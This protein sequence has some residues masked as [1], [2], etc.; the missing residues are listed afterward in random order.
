MER[1]LILI[2][3]DGVQRSLIGPII[4]RFEQKGF[5]LIGCKL[6]QMSKEKAE[7]HYQEHA[8]RP[9]YERLV[10]F[11]T[12]GPI[13]AMV[14]QA[15]QVIALSRKIIGKT[16]AIDMIPGTIRGDFAHHTNTNL[17]HGSDSPENAEREIANL[18]ESYEIISYHRNISEWM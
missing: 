6:M 18:F 5:Q 11:I 3:P 10:Q 12:S 17:V 13:V 15:D 16:E 7:N 4:Q 9:Y 2:K 1:T 14:W 8:G